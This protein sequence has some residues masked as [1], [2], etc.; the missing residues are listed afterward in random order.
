MCSTRTPSPFCLYTSITSLSSFITR[1]SIYTPVPIFMTKPSVPISLENL[2]LK[3][4]RTSTLL[5]H[6]L[7]GMFV[8]FHTPGVSTNQ[9]TEIPE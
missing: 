8:I 2:F 7:G 5:P 9:P 3:T 4:E 1:P 6:L